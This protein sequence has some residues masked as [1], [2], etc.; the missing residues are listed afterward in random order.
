VATDDVLADL[1]RT[2]R[3]KGYWTGLRL[4]EHVARALAEAPDLTVSDGEETVA[5]G[6]LAEAG[7]HLASRFEGLGLAAGDPVFL[8]VT[9]PIADIATLIALSRVDTVVFFSPPGAAVGEVVRALG[10]SGARTLLSA[11]RG[12]AL[13][14]SVVE[15]ARGVSG[16]TV[17]WRAAR[18]GLRNARH[19]A[20]EVERPQLTDLTRYVTFTSGTT[21]E[22]KGIQ[23]NAD[24]LAFAGRWA[25]EYARPGQGAVVGLVALAHAAGLAFSLMSALAHR[26]DLLVLHGKWRPD[27]AL[28]QIRRHEAA[29]TLA[30]PTHLLDLVRSAAAGG[31]PLDGFTM[32][33]GGAPVAPELVRTADDAG[34]VGCRVFG[35]SECLGH[36][37]ASSDDPLE[38][39][40]HTEGRSFP[41][42][43]DACLGPDGR[44][45]DAPAEGEAAC[46]GP[47]MFLGYLDE[48]SLAD[49][50]T[51]EGLLRTGDRISVDGNG[52]VT[53]LGRIK[54][55]IIRGG[56]NVDPV[57]VSA[58][59]EAVPG[60]ERAL[61]IGVPD[62][63]LGE[64][65]GAALEVAPG[66]VVTPDDVLARLDAEG[67][68]KFKWPE[69]WLIADELPTTPVGKLDRRQVIGALAS[70]PR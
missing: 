51:D 32:S 59:L 44:V 27:H 25:L 69:R 10:R 9:D 40:M 18:I 64:R 62:A 13:A 6:D 41:G 60:V 23:H 24:T 58:A 61:V 20:A 31:E 43:I 22:P 66:H 35:L 17:D 21:G 16:L 57:E 29:W 3:A 5:L 26:R 28:A 37:S 56:E 39:R 47:S 46:A 4:D 1:W 70:Q 63:R 34:I 8:L 14:E 15:S 55:I 2:Y 52:R 54:D 48:R 11:R 30:T 42:T 50:L 19:E 45:L 38:V 33:V 53:V 67:V 68:P 12:E 36:T 65:V 7:E 49:R